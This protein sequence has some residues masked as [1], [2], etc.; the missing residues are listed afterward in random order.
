MKNI[1]NIYN[2]NNKYNHNKYNNNITKKFVWC[3]D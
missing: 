1:N 3:S 2:I